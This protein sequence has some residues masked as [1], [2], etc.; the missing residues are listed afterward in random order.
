MK[1]KCKFLFFPH[2]SWFDLTRVRRSSVIT[3]ISPIQHIL[4]EVEYQMVKHLITSYIS[5]NVY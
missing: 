2:L 4:D 3:D 5:I 1:S